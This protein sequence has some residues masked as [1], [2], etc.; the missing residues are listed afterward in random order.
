MSGFKE[1][2]I[3]WTDFRKFFRYYILWKSFE[4]EPTSV[5]GMERRKGR[6]TYITKLTVAFRN[7]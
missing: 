4:W 5:M 6:Q 3:F 1:I 2:G 7:F